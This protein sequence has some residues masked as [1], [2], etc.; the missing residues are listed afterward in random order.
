MLIAQDIQG[1]QRRLDEL[2]ERIADMDAELQAN[3]IKK[4]RAGNEVLVPIFQ[5]QQQQ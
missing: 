2:N 5:Q 1:K 3:P 4:V